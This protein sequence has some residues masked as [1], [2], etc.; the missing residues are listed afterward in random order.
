MPRPRKTVELRELV[1]WVNERNV[2]ST[3]DPKVREGWN[4]FLNSLLMEADAYA[5]FGFLRSYELTGEAEGKPPGIIYDTSGNNQH[6]FPDE[7]R[8][9]FF[10]RYGL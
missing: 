7:T 2:T 4:S 3:C 10:L 5:G 6:Q 1:K 8:I 9:R